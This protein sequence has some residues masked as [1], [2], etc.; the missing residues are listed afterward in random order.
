[1]AVTIE[2]HYITQQAL[3]TEISAKFV[4]IEQDYT[5]DY[6][7][8]LKQSL[9]DMLILK[10]KGLNSGEKIAI[11]LVDIQNDFVLADFALYA[12]GGENTVTSNM[13][14]LDAVTELA[15]V[16]GSLTNKLEIV[17]SQDAH[18]Q[19][20]TIDSMEAR[21]LQ[22]GYL[23]YANDGKTDVARLKTQQAIDTEQTELL[24]MNPS[25]GQYGL[26]CMTGTIGAAIAK[27]IEDRLNKL[28]AAGFE[29]T[30]FG[31]INFSGPEAGM[32]LHK[33]IDLSDQKYQ[34]TDYSIYHYSNTSYLQFYK[35]K[36]YKSVLVTGICGDVCVQQAAEGLKKA[37]VDLDVQVVDACTHYLAIPAIGKH[38]DATRNAV[39][40]SYA[41]KKV[42][43]LAFPF[44]RSNRDSDSVLYHQDAPPGKPAPDGVQEV[45]AL[46]EFYL[47][48][49][50]GCKAIGAA[51]A[52]T[53]VVTAFVSLTS[54]MAVGVAVTAGVAVVALT[55]CLVAGMGIFSYTKPKQ[56]NWLDVP[57]AEKFSPVEA[58]ACSQ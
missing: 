16:D 52:L 49:R 24:P 17:T 5:S 38:Y 6:H 55:T 54:M 48:K 22:A 4:Q 21:A 53:L 30:R 8:R 47:G 32:M 10:L 40:A 7:Q 9:K 13:A 20:R 50:S 18:R 2:D 51:L 27:P 41:T 58:G 45:N 19:G 56:I 31:K 44:A 33:G 11:T 25:E 36:P 35:N 39:E 43:V 26:H 57:A 37:F 1:M 28:S 46:M 42:N 14:L 12:G 3:A 15:A 34:S 29:V 23:N